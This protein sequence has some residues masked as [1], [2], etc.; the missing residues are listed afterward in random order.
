MFPGVGQGS[1]TTMAGCQLFPSYGCKFGRSPQKDDRAGTLVSASTYRKK[2]A[3]GCGGV[4]WQLTDACLSSICFL[5]NKIQISLGDPCQPDIFAGQTDPIFQSW[6]L[7]S[8]VHSSHHSD[9]FRDCHMIQFMPRRFFYR[10]FLGEKAFH[11]SVETIFKKCSFQSSCRGS[12]V[13]E[14]DQEP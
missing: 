14:S 12:V 5:L 13:N 10:I 7:D 6:T 1:V 11:S 3:Y 9:Y 2:N 4:K 8:L